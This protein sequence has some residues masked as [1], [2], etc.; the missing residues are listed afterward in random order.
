MAKKESAEKAIRD[1]RRKTRRRFSAE[2]KIRIG[3]AGLRG[4]DSIAELCRRAGIHQ[5]VY[6]R[7]SKAFLEAGRKRLA[8]DTER[9]ASSGAVSALRQESAQLKTALAEMMRH[10]FM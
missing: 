8:G 9:E 4:E 10:Q 5:N 2:E 3:L 1:V 7:W 6:Y